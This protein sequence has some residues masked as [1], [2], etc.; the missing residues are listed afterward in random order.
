MCLLAMTRNLLFTMALLPLAYVT[1][2][3][4]PGPP[5]TVPRHP[6]A[7]QTTVTEA[8]LTPTLESVVAQYEREP[9]TEAAAAVWTSFA[10][11]ADKIA[12]LKQRVA[13]TV[14]GVR[15][16]AEVERIELEQ[17]YD[18]QLARFASVHA[19]IQAAREALD[20]LATASDP[21]TGIR[22][23]MGALIHGNAPLVHGRVTGRDR[24][25]WSSERWEIQ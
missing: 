10:A 8:R 1:A 23:A 3:K 19:R 12:K 15:A 4:I 9:T 20:A 17:K 16:E 18:E 11:T 14:G 2:R 13:A 6:A 25:G 24:S 7:L 21:S 5:T 22:A